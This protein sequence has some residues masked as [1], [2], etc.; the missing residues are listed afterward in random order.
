MPKDS[1][2]Q[3]TPFPGPDTLSLIVTI[4]QSCIP[5]FWSQKRE[6]EYNKTIRCTTP[7]STKKRKEKQKTM[8]T[9][10]TSNPKLLSM[11]E[12]LLPVIALVRR[13]VFLNVDAR[14][15]PSVLQIALDSVRLL[16]GPS[17]AAGVAQR[18]GQK[19]QRMRGRHHDQGQPDAEV[20]YL[21]DLAP[22]PCQHGDAD[23]LCY[24]DARE[25]L[26]RIST[27]RREHYFS[28][29]GALPSRQRLRERPTPVCRC[30]QSPPARG[31]E[32]KRRET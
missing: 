26:A 12:C 17:L 6:K 31:P 14:R 11:C 15:Q 27:V 30:R 2:H 21:K 8:V 13:S 25:N 28:L 29:S 20:V 18:H 5:I 1:P 9:R 22:R 7:K 19:N 10:Q 23:E 3:S 32:P 4:Y 24:R 16:C